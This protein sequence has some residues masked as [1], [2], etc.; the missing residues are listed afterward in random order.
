VA[1]LLQTEAR[2]RADLITV[3]ETVIELDLTEPGDTFGSTSTVTFDCR[4]PGAS[5]FI[6]FTGS[7]L[8]GA[9]L[10]GEPV[11]AEAWADGR[12]TLSGLGEHNVVVIDGAMSYSSSGEGMC[13]HVDPAD[14]RTY[15]YAMSF[16]DAGPAWFACF[17]QP[18]LKSRYTLEVRAPEDWTVHGN[19]PSTPTAPGHWR[20]E[21]TAPLSTYFVTLVA[22]PYASVY[23]EHDGIR[24]GVHVRASLAAELEAEAADILTVTRQCFDYYHQTFGIRYPFGEY[25]QAFVPDFNAGAMENPGC[26][27]LRDQYIYR[28][29]VTTAERGVRAGTIAH[30]MAHMWFGDLVTMRWWDD[31]WLNEAFAEYMAH[32]A[33]QEATAY[34]LWTDFG[35]RRKAW[36]MVADQSPSTHP[37]AGNGSTDAESAL[38]QFDGISY[39][40]GAAVLKQL[41]AYVGL[42]TF[43]DGLRRYFRAH[44][45]A[46]ATFA[47]LLDAWTAAGADGLDDWA[48][49]WLATSGMDLLEVGSV[50]GQPVLRR[51][52]PPGPSRGRRPHALSVAALAADGSEV[53]RIPVLL[54]DDHAPI[55]L[56]VDADGLTLVPDAADEAWARLRPAGG[57][58]EL[59]PI[60]AIDDPLTRTVCYRGVADAVGH[61]ELDPERALE[62]IVA[63][64]PGEADVELLR[65]TLQLAVDQL[66]AG[67]CPPAL[68]SERR[69]RIAEAVRGILTD[70]DPGSDRQLVAFR[71]A[72]RTVDDP[73]LLH[74]WLDGTGLPAGISP[75]P[76]LRW[77]AASRLVVRAQGS[78]FDPD[79]LVD[80]MSAGDRSGAGR[81]HAAR[82]QA[83]IGT[84]AAKRAAL[85]LV[86]EPSGMSA[87]EVYATAEGLFHPEQE[88]VT[89]SLVEP[90]FA[91]INDTARFRSG[92]ALS[93]TALKA[94]P[95]TMTEPSTLSLAGQALDRDDLH[96]AIRRSLVDAT[97]QLARA[98]AARQTY[99]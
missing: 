16:L 93:R 88:T 62:L 45:Y 90:Y 1:S 74:R 71:V 95:L 76:E 36:G 87:Y 54:S 20:I 41:V 27:T 9:L 25:H 32:R 35:I 49:V 3:R 86:L 12:I 84:P 34:D 15:L 69:G 50:G 47:D 75:D 85:D 78:G 91:R 8:T 37:V 80:R 42:D 19:G 51:I 92:W 96:P 33:C 65:A 58:A 55:Q 23:D 82:L 6:E 40:K 7:V 14:G 83:L 39:A 28:G 56:D 29:A 79:G 24:L 52:A 64:A 61:A 63:A 94:F 60:T 59:L 11:P 43:L 67:F 68:R 53:A 99:P 77:A 57:W 13:R 4:R 89:A 31:L 72:L 66:V 81:V 73:D 10:N 48:R 70:A 17:D 26:V 97:D 22:G 44:E 30:E 5:T 98:V 46:N 38:A 21:P 18:D 2:D